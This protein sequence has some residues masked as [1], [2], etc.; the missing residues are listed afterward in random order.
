VVAVAVERFGAR[1]SRVADDRAVRRVDDGEAAAGI[2]DAG[3][4]GC[5]GR[6]R[7]ARCAGGSGSIPASPSGRP[8][9]ASCWSDHSAST[10]W[11]RQA[12]DSSRRQAAR[13]GRR[14]RPSPPSW[15]RARRPSKRNPAR[16]GSC[17]CAS[18]RSPR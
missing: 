14:N 12:R 18:G 7:A 4:R 15:G 8:G 5:C 2:V 17:R 9:A 16:R 3:E 13:R 1:R 10:R 11:R 6:R